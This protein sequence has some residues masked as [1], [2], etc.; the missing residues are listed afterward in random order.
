MSTSSSSYPCFSRP[1]RES[2]TNGTLLKEYEA[3]LVGVRGVREPG[4]PLRV[5]EGFL[6]MLEDAGTAVPAITATELQQFVMEQGTF[7]QRKTLASVASHLRGFLRFL[8][9]RRVMEL[10]LSEHVRRPRV[11]TGERQPRYLQDWQVREVL[12]SVDLEARTGKRDYALLLLLAVYG[13][14]SHEVTGL[15]LEDL[16]WRSNRL[17]VRARK[18]GD[19]LELPLVPDVA[20]ALA[21]YLKVRPVSTCRDVFLCFFRPHRPL[22]SGGLN[23][24]AA[25]AIRRCDFTVAHPGTHTF[26]Y[27]RAQALF[28]AKRPLP[29]IASA[30]GHRDLR[31]TLGYLSFTVHPLRELALNAGEELA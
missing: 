25:K 27:S 3:H 8:A 20:H 7:Y 29:E 16:D 13:L 19:A 6:H 5:V 24:V 1:P 9:L 14:R 30:L 2:T 28:A 17:F 31:T 10:D 12:R 11:F 15:L 18:C 26:R 23:V 21:A 22:R 4:S